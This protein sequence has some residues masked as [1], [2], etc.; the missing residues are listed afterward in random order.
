MVKNRDFWMPFAPSVLSERGN[1]YYET[2]VARPD[3][4]LADLITI[5]HPE[6][7][8]HHTLLWYHRLH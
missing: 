3:L 2:A 7:P 4:L 5:F 6:I 1:D 8:L